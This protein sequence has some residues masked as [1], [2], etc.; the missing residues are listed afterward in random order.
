M[1]KIKSM[2]IIPLISFFLLLTITTKS[3]ADVILIGP[4][5]PVYETGLTIMR[6][7]FG[8]M[9]V[10]TVG[11][12]LLC[13][14]NKTETMEKA[15]KIYMVIVA[16]LINVWLICS[17]VEYIFVLER[18]EIINNILP[19]IALFVVLSLFCISL[20]YRLFRMTEKA[21]RYMFISFI[22][23]LVLLVMYKIF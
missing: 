12:L 18:F 13:Y 5:F 22:T 20:L 14:E 16:H 8:L 15:L 1:K 7:I 4:K 3:N 10:V 23:V 11:I 21:N 9:A 17:A 2:W 6:I 19:L